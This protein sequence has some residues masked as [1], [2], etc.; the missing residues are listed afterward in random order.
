[1]NH[2]SSQYS[3]GL[4][5][6]FEFGHHDDKN[7]NYYSRNLKVSLVDFQTQ[8]AFE[9][10]SEADLRALGHAPPLDGN[11]MQYFS[12][13]TGTKYAIKIDAG[14]LDHDLYYVP[15]VCVGDK[16][17]EHSTGQ[18][19]GT[20][21]TIYFNRPHLIVTGFKPGAAQGFLF[22]MDPDWVEEKK[23]KGLPCNRD[24]SNCI[25]VSVQFYQKDD[26][27]M[28]DAQEPFFP[29]YRA[30]GSSGGGGG[31]MGYTTR[32][33]EYVAPVETRSV[34]CRFTPMPNAKKEIKFVL[35]CNDSPETLLRAY[36][37]KAHAE[38]ITAG[39]HELRAH[40]AYDAATDDVLRHQATAWSRLQDATTA[41]GQLGS[42][43]APAEIRDEFGCKDM[44]HLIQKVNEAHQ[45][46]VELQNSNFALKAAKRIMKGATDAAANA[47]IRARDANAKAVEAQ[48]AADAADAAKAADAAAA[49][50]AAAEP[51]AA[52][53]AAAEAATA[54]AAAAS[55]TFASN[56]GTPAMLD[57]LHL[58]AEL[59]KLRQENK[60][61]K[62]NA[63]AAEAEAT[64]NASKK[65]RV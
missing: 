49:A 4:L 62:Q 13:R 22:E 8:Q 30:L 25:T 21:N 38:A 2:H 34:S 36:A 37:K 45:G 56:D 7:Q 29:M 9:P 27:C 15:K 53:E 42:D 16:T 52:A 11:A 46:L 47:K 35:L 14:V 23:Q 28:L 31:G 44:R 65:P 63:A 20:T 54:A 10:L 32:S 5:R 64:A 1:M 43:S 24:G 51:A 60:K 39:Q 61:L 59:H 18:A 26:P 6:C 58:M 50:E 12:C 40:N 41:I 19:G 55:P 33:D 48:A 3:S 17:V 57:Q